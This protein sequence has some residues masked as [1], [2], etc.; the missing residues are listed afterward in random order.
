[1]NAPSNTPSSAPTRART[2][3]GPLAGMK[4]LVLAQIMACPT[5]GMMLA[6]LGAEVIK[7]EKLP[8]GDDARNYRE[9]RVNGESAP[10]MMLNR[11]K[12]GLALDLKQAAGKDVLKRMVK[13]SDVLIENYRRG[14]MEK[15]GLGFEVLSQINPGLIYSAVSGY[16]RTGP[17]QDRGGFDL[18]AQGF[19]GL[20]SITGE[21]GGAP[22]KMSKHRLSVE[23]PAPMLG[24]HSREILTEFGFDAAEITALFA[25]R[26]VG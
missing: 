9:P 3:T 12:R 5:A 14:A 23:H 10:F 17:Y 6:D 18:I 22:I 7:V 26:V 20:M 15:L 4:V 21:P 25:Q 1:M 11:N 8:G 24:Q 2:N 13:R 19:A 16:G